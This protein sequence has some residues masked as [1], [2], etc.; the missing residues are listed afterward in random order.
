MI[1]TDDKEMV[2]A[3]K[4]RGIVIQRILNFVEES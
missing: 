2:V 1:Y 4:F 3:G